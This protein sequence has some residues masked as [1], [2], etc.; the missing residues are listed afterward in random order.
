MNVQTTPSPATRGTVV[1]RRRAEFVATVGLVGY[2]VCSSSQS[3]HPTFPEAPCVSGLRLGSAGA[4]PNLSCDIAQVSDLGE[5]FILAV[6]GLLSL[7][8]SRTTRVLLALL[9]EEWLP[10]ML[11]SS[12]TQAGSHIDESC[13][14]GRPCWQGCQGWER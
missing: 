12:S 8:T 3:T 1:L 9:G 4:F 11:S 7:V 2:R 6:L 13:Q 14:E 5:D 10:S